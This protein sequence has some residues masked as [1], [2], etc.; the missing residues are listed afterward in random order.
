MTSACVYTDP[1][2]LQLMHDEST[3]SVH[4]EPGSLIMKATC[5]LANSTNNSHQSEKQ[6]ETRAE[7]TATTRS[8]EEG[9]YDAGPSLGESK[10]DDEQL[11]HSNVHLSPVV[12]PLGKL[13]PS[14]ANLLKLVCIH[15]WTQEKVGIVYRQPVWVYPVKST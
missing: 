9:Q 11:S 8:P 4:P 6:P 3:K 13:T 2:A 7:L 10:G 5:Y 15:S 14:I 12:L 1:I